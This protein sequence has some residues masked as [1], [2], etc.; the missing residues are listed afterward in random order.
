MNFYIVSFLDKVD[1]VCK[2]EYIPTE[3]DILRCR[4]RT[5]GIVE[6][7]FEVNNQLFKMYDVG[8]QRN[9]RRKWIH[10]FEGVT[11]VIFVAALNT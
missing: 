2:S 7:E 4:K 6:I 5:T 10:A 1:I 3:Q 11:A 8:G 9:E